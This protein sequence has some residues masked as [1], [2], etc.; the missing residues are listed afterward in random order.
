MDQDKGLLQDLATSLYIG[1]D[2]PLSKAK[3]LELKVLRP[4]LPGPFRQDEHDFQDF[5]EKKPFQRYMWRL[6]GS[7]NK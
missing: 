6:I 2:L 7:T 3:L 5:L 4:F 1:I